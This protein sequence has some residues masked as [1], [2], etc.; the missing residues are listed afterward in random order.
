MS[1]AEVKDRAAL[2][3]SLKHNVVARL[4]LMPKKGTCVLGFQARLDLP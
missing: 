3:R 1:G 4:A 2:D